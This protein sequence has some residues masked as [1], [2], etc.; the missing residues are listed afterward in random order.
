MRVKTGVKRHKKHKKIRKQAK[1]FSGHRGRSV[2]GA[3]E[4]LFHAGKHA[5]VSRRLKKRDMR[6]LWVVRLNAATREHGL[7][8]S[9][10]I[11]ALND[12]NITLDRKILS[13]IAIMDPDTFGEIVK[14]VT[15]K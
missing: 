14:Q 2:R 5:R 15:S 6:K 13:E 11:K 7:V 10:F 3:K 8:Y 1:G 9:H 4:G 12:K